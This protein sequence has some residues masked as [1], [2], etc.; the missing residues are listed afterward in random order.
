[1]WSSMTVGVEAVGFVDHEDDLSAA[2]GGFGGDQL[3]GLW[4]ERGV[5]EAGCAA[6]RGD[7]GDRRLP[8][9]PRRARP[10]QT[11]PD[12]RPT[13]RLATV[14]SAGRHGRCL[15]ANGATSSV[16]S[17]VGETGD[18]PRGLYSLRDR[19]G[20]VVAYERFSCAPGPVG[21]RYN[22]QVLAA[23]GRTP[24]GLVDVTTDASGLQIRVEVRAGG[25]VVRGGVADGETVWVRTGASG[26]DTGEDTAP[27]AGFTGRSPGFLVAVARLLGLRTGTS[28]RVRLVALTEPALAPV[29]V[30]VAWSLSTVEEYPTEVGPLPVERYQTADL[31]SG[32]P[33]AVQLAGDV[34]LAAT[35]VE[36]DALDTPPTPPSGKSR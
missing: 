24:T 18:V 13:S 7:D 19:D 26:E 34:V 4:D 36:L 27:A 25:W 15:R 29:P 11:H 17:G 14:R 20:A 21:W 32:Q 3:G 2:F 30:E 22:A 9:R 23:D 28:S 31:A 5:V 33:A 16:A 10:E 8:R 6:E 1:M 12:L 35:G